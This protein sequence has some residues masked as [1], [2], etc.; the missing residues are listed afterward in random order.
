M[1]RIFAAL[2]DRLSAAS[3]E[4]CGQEWRRHLLADLQGVVVEIG[5]GTGHNLAQY[6]ATLDRLVATEPE[7]AMR[8]RLAARVAEV[9]PPFPV[10]IVDAPADWLP[11]ADGA[12]DAVVSTLVLCTVPDPAAALAE[13]R[14]VL[15]PGGRLVF[16][17]HVVAPEKPRRHRWQRRIEPLWRLAFGGCHLTRDTVAAI[18]AAGFDVVDHRRESMRKAS[19]VV[20]TTERGFAVKPA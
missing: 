15:R 8:A 14:R 13:A 12:A 10:E 16:L 9:S 19:P 7:R 6:P 4:A 11:L 5:A 18:G 3:E 17:E 20:R 2:Y 1:G